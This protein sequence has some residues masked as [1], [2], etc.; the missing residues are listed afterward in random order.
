MLGMRITL[1]RRE[2]TPTVWG[3][4]ETTHG[5]ASPDCAASHTQARAR[6]IAITGTAI[7][8][9]TALVAG[10]VHAVEPRHTAL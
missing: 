8:T 4:G 2:Y 3:Q 7:G 10:N 5:D 6:T 1:V 9:I